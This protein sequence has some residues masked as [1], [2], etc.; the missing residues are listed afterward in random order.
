MINCFKSSFIKD[1]IL[2]SLAENIVE[3]VNKTFYYI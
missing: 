3:D 1:T 2:V